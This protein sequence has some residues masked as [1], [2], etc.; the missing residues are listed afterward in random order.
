MSQPPTLSARQR[1]DNVGSRA[2]CILLTDGP[3]SVVASNLTN[4]TDGLAAIDPN[5]DFWMPR[6]RKCPREARLGAASILLPKVTRDTLTNWWLA[7]P[8]RAN[9]PNWDIASTAKIDGVRGL[10]LVEAKAYTRELSRAGKSYRRK[11]P[12]S[13]P[14]TFGSCEDDHASNAAQIQRAC[15]QASTALDELIPGWNLSAK[16]HYQLSNRF[17][18][19]W[20]LASLEVPVVLVYLGFLNAKEME[21]RGSPFSSLEDWEAYVKS[22]AAQIVP[23]KAWGATMKV[24]GTPLRALLCARDERL[25]DEWLP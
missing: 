8:K 9:T 20:K 10:L 23:D 13:D 19:S 24:H 17:A 12:D 15:A 21:L 22:H 6:G 2:R 5:S 11:T 16:S 7:A 3:A 4:L 18:W 25:R 14:N 1:R